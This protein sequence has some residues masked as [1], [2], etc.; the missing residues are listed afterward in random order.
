MSI[1][2]VNKYHILTV[3]SKLMRLLEKKCLCLETYVLYTLNGWLAIQNIPGNL[4]FSQ[5]G[6]ISFYFDLTTTCETD[7][8]FK[9]SDHKSI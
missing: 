8:L 4:K 7:L 3:L 9:I 5:K 2:N 6:Q 1:Y